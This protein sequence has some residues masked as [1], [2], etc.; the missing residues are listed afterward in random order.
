M[1]DDFLIRALI[2][3]VVVAVVAGPF[4]CFVV[5]RKM[6]YFGDTMAHSA[7]LGVTLSLLL[8]V[9]PGI[10]VFIVATGI[11][12]ALV[13]LQRR[14]DLPADTVLGILSHST[15]ALGLLAIATLAGTRIDLMSYLFGDV[16]TVTASELKLM[17]LLGPCA[18]L[19]LLFIWRPL[20]AGTVNRDLAQAE[21]RQPAATEL[22]YLI[23]L[24]AVI[25][26]AIKVIGILLITA[27][28]V[29]PAATARRFAGTPEMMAVL[30]SIIGAV[31]VAAGLLLSLNA[32]TPAAPAIVVVALA[33]F[34]VSVA[35]PR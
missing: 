15:L 6:A 34:L 3:G 24:S 18:L 12:I 5:W 23:L 17:L 11:G 4:G 13:G 29:I 19:A 10:G 25:A 14:A 30:A 8:E 2:A 35:L 22:V 20:L 27:L 9:H 1:I 16:L 32:D 26:M 31:A 7:L 28:L 21:T 33:M